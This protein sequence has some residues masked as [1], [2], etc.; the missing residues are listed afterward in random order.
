[1]TNAEKALAFQHNK[2]A[3]AST[4]LDQCARLLTLANRLKL[5]LMAKSGLADWERKLSPNRANFDHLNILLWHNAKGDS[6]VDITNTTDL[7]ILKPVQNGKKDDCCSTGVKF[8]HVQLELDYSDLATTSAGLPTSST[9]LRS[10]YYIQL[11]Q[12]TKDL[13][14]EKGNAYRLSTYIGGNNL[15]TL[16]A[17]EVKHTI[18][19][20]THQDGPYN[21]LTPSFNLTSCRTNSTGVYSELKSMLSVLPL[22]PSIIPYLWSW[23]PATPSS[24]NTSLITFGSPMLTL[25]ERQSKL[26]RRFTTPT[27]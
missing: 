24:L 22:T 17:A 20:V 26:A 25:T 5:M 16:S 2:T 11:P 7:S 15:Q 1:M 14:N 27:S 12:D 18:L 19:D 9:V 6:I 8:D 23:S 3:L 10:E 21:L 4:N 13:T